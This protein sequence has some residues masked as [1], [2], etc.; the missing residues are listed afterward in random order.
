MGWLLEGAMWE[1]KLQGYRGVETAV[2]NLVAGEGRAGAE[3]GGPQAS[4]A[5]PF[6]IPAVEPLYSWSAVSHRG[7]WRCMRTEKF[8]R[9]SP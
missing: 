2:L 9:V 5:G 1:V 4:W 6:E 7:Q 3:V 8:L